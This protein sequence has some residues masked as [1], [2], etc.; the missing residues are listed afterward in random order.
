MSLVTFTLNPELF[1]FGGGV[2][3]AGEFLL[4]K[5]KT[6]YYPYVLPFIKDQKMVI[7]SLG[8][9]AGMYGAAYLVK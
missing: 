4:D 8:N 3:N 1:I 6:H 9:D 5:I 7:A 2:S